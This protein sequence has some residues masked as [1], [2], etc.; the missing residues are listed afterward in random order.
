MPRKI[1]GSA[2]RS[3]RRKDGVPRELGTRRMVCLG[4]FVAQQG[5]SAGKMVRL[6]NF[7]AQ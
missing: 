5:L 4:N 1:C 2:R 7:V 6:G 3:R